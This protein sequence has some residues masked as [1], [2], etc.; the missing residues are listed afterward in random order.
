V[1]GDASCPK[2]KV[3]Q[4]LDPIGEVCPYPTAKTSVILKKM[5]AVEVLEV[6]TEFYS[7]RQTFPNLM[8]KPGYPYELGD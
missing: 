4:R 7:A 3:D 8:G 6:T 5:A 2:N 1:E